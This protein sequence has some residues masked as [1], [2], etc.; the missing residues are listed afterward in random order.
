MA[1]KPSIKRVATPSVVKPQLSRLGKIL[2]EDKQ[3][4]EDASRLQLFLSLA[5]FFDSDLK[6]NLKKTSFELD[7]K[8]MTYDTHS[9]L[10][11]K[12]YPSVRKYITSY[13]D[14]EQLAQARKTLSDEGL[15]KAKD[16]IDMQAIIEGKQKS[17]VNTNI[18]VFFMPQK[19]YNKV[20]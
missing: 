13:L 8:Y 19:E 6:N 11:F 9:W 20:V 3:L 2:S 15:S 12:N 10:E 5:S 4:G 17:D 1:E 14:E 18:I 7:D 16:A